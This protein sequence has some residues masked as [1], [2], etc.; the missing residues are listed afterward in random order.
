LPDAG[1]DR[2]TLSMVSKAFFTGSKYLVEDS[3]GRHDYLR[4]D[5][6]RFL[7]ALAAAGR[8]VY[9]APFEADE[10]KGRYLAALV[11]LND[12]YFA[13]REYEADAKGKYL[14]HDAQAERR[15]RVRTAHRLSDAVED[16]RALLAAHD[17]L[18]SAGV[19]HVDRTADPSDRDRKCAAVR[20]TILGCTD[21][22]VADGWFPVVEA[23]Y[24]SLSPGEL[25]AEDRE[26]RNQ[27]LDGT[28]ESA[29][30]RELLGRPGLERL[31]RSD[32][33]RIRELDRESPGVDPRV[34]KRLL[35]DYPWYVDHEA[36]DSRTA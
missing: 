11:E 20:A 21:R 15:F 23:Y 9:G 3:D 5:G 36:A 4:F 19:D 12:G 2:T 22:A 1:S 29:G 14:K 27:R 33:Q 18:V 32:V 17:A 25:V 7:S 34:W 35:E 30:I 28:E 31:S 24:Y 8:K 10:A 26:R 16:L 6:E 13:A